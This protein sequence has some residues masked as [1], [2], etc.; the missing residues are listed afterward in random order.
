VPEILR[1]LLADD[2]PAIL[3]LVSHMLQKDFEIAGIVTD[4]TLI[5][6]EAVKLKPDV[7]LLDI[8]MPE[9]N[10]F[11]VTKLL[12]DQH[13]SAKVILLT[14][15]EEFEFIRAAF[16]AGASGYV[17]KSRISADLRSAIQAV[18]LGK[19]FIP[20]APIAS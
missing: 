8:S 3:D 12:R 16:D 7:I 19:V 14:V 9:L 15:H 13:C 20:D 18:H 4:S 5:V 17:F 6:Q 2:N 10:G 11:E 1:I